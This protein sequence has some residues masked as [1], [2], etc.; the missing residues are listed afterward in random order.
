MKPTE[1]QIGLQQL[2]DDI[3][4]W[5]DATF[6]NGQRNPAI[7][8]HLKKEVDELIEALNILKVLG[9]DNSV[10]IG[11]FG[12][13]LSKTE[14]EYADCFMLLLDSAHHFGMTA[15]DILKAA[16]KKL[17]INKQRKWGNPDENGVIEH[18]KD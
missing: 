11:E 16:S 6:G 9:C 2:M 12:R 13:Q 10:G 14:M 18:I 17:E 5:S 4:E 15:D 3:S 7:V 1:Q 8:H